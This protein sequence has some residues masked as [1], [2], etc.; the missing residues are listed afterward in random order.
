MDQYF[1][2]AIPPLVAALVSGYGTYHYD[3]VA[4]KNLFP[5]ELMWAN[6]TVLSNS[7]CGYY[8]PHEIT[9]NMLCAFG[10]GSDSCQGDSGGPLEALTYY[11][12]GLREQLCFPFSVRGMTDKPSLDQHYS[13][14]TGPAHF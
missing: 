9:E 4:K 7:E 13:V 3:K 2:S 1:I 11:S 8:E 12:K 6:V 10:Y 14:S 5:N